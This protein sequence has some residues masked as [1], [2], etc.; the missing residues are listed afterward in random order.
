MFLANKSKDFFEQISGETTMDLKRIAILFAAIFIFTPQTIQTC[1]QSR[2]YKEMSRAE[3]LDFVH[4]QARRIAREI[5]GN[6]YEFTT[7]FEVD[8]QQALTRYAER[9]DNPGA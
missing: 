6:D 3:R 4:Q 5:S 7:A 9:I 2:L 1:A 8:V